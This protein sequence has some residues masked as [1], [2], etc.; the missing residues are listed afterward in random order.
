MDHEVQ[1]RPVLLG[2]HE[3]ERRDQECLLGVV[4]RED[5]PKGVV[6][7][8]VGRRRAPDHDLEVRVARSPVHLS[9]RL[10]GPYDR[11]RDRQ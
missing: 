9:P 4:E 3:G 2:G 5:R 11:E 10:L 6:D 1:H 8:A 7:V